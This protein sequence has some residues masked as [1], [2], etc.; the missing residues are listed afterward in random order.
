MFWR[1]LKRQ[2][3]P[4]YAQNAIVSL[5][6]FDNILVAIPIDEMQEHIRIELLDPKVIFVLFMNGTLY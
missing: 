3:W 1:P 6:A 2:L 5:S 4:N